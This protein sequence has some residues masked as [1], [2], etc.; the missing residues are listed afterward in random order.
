MNRLALNAALLPTGHVLVAA[1]ADGDTPSS[2]LALTTASKIHP[3]L[4]VDED[5]VV[6]AVVE[7]S[8]T[9]TMYD[10]RYDGLCCC[11]GHTVALCHPELLLDNCRRSS[12]QHMAFSAY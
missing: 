8:M 11:A 9:L 4:V 6:V 2:Y 10:R 1:A 7:M 12:A 5:V 3:T